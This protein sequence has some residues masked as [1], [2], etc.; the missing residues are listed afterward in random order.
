MNY[1][2][3]NATRISNDSYVAKARAKATKKYYSQAD[4]LDANLLVSAGEAPKTYQHLA[5]TAKRLAGALRSLKKLDVSGAFDALG[6]PLGGKHARRMN[7]KANRARNDKISDTA[8]FVSD[9]WLELKYGWM[10]LISDAYAMAEIYSER[11][12][13]VHD[14][15]VIDVRAKVTFDPPCLVDSSGA[16]GVVHQRNGVAKHSIIG[17]YQLISPEMRQLSALGLLNPGSLVYE[18]IPYS[19]VFDWFIPLGSYIDSLTSLAGLRFIGGCETSQLIQTGAASLYGWE[20][21][22]GERTMTNNEKLDSYEIQRTVLT[23]DPDRLLIL[24]AKDIAS[25][26]NVDKLMTSLALLN[27]L[28]R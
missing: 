26:M 19:F 23:D 9:S 1:L 21:W 2:F 22:N 24:S 11:M 28:R 16:I 7:R 8:G 18:L 6:I 15:I 4:A 12:G 3:P 20:Q 25:F 27:S 10:P 17:R 5:S 14:D 13:R